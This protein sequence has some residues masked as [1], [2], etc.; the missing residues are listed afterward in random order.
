[1]SLGLDPP[2]VKTWLVNGTV[3]DVRSVLAGYCYDGA[4]LDESDVRDIRRTAVC[5][6]IIFGLTG[7]QIL[8]GM[9]MSARVRKDTTIPEYYIGVMERGLP[10]KSPPLCFV[11]NP[12]RTAARL[13]H[14]LDQL[15]A[16]RLG[17]TWLYVSAL[18]SVNAP[19]VPNLP[20]SSGEFG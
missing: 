17:M 16:K 12:V 13:A 2:N 11:K 1:M 7:S 4:D 20:Q 3:A 6:A 9:A 18:G 8:F 14:Q 10:F 19:S 15:V 5:D